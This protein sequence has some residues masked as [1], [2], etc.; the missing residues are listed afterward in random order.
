M[1]F[2]IDRD[3][4]NGFKEYPN[5]GTPPFKFERLHVSSVDVLLS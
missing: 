4:F 3:R 1:N 5:F 2:E